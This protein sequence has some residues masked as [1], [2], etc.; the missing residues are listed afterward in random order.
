M[1]NHRVGEMFVV[2]ISLLSD[3]DIDT[4]TQEKAL[5]IIDKIGNKV[6][7]TT[8]L[9]AEFDDN[10]IPNTKLGRVLIKAFLPEKYEAWKNK[11]Y[12]DEEYYHKV[13]KPFRER[14]GFW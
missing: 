5:D 7:A 11:S 3:D 6:I 1:G 8:S 4:L 9:D 12:E 2:G 13:Y 10:T 14:Y